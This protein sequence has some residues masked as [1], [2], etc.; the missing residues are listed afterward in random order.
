MKAAFCGLV[1]VVILLNNFVFAQNDSQVLIPL[2][3]T[4]VEDFLNKNPE[5]NG[6]G[7][8]IIVIDTGIDMGIEGLTKTPDGD[9]KVI[10]VQDFTHQGNINFYEAEIEEEEGVSFFINEEMNFKINGAEKLN[11]KAV[12]EKYYI[13]NFAE[14]L[15]MNSSSNVFDINNNGNE[16]DNFYFV[17]FKVSENQNNYWVLYIDTDA[18]GDLSDE[19][20]LRSYKEKFDTFSIPNGKGL[21]DLT[22]AVNIF[23][24]EKQ[25][26]FFFDDGGHGTHCSGIA[27]GFNIGGN[28]VNDENSSGYAYLH[29]VG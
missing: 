26:N 8:I 17:T 15:L 2:K 25:V 18:D 9:T 7:T 27:A 22:I 3:S 16:N 14:K 12:D 13:G 19:K 4:G 1:I 23:P 28:G 5:C 10:D 20:P 21:P 11:L 29:L 24:E 6:K